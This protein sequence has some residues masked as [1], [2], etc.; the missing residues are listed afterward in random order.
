MTPEEIIQYCL[1]K[2]YVTEETPFGPDTAVY[3][4]CGKMFLLI[5]LDDPTSVNVKCNP[6]KAI[7]WREQYEE[8][9]PGFHM[10]KTHWNTVS[11][12]GRLSNRLIKEMIDL[13]YNEVVAGLPKKVR[14]SLFC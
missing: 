4:V 10:N 11:I 8:V 7:E 12:V 2:Q 3:K 1:S 9:Q 5:G 6:E 14:L 13:S